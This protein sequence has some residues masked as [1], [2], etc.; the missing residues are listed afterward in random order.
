[1][2]DRYR[3][4]CIDTITD[5]NKSVATRRISGAGGY[6]DWLR[7]V[8]AALDIPRARVAGLSYGGWLAAQL[9]LRASE[10]V[11]HMVLLAPGGTLAPFSSQFLA[12]TL[13]QMLLRSPSRLRDSL[14]WL[15]STPDALADP[16]VDL[17]RVSMLTTRPLRRVI[18]PTVLTDDELRRIRMPVTVLIGEREVIYRG[19]PKAAL[20][21]AQRLIPNVRTR[22]LAGANHMLTLDCPDALITEMSGALA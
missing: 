4:Y 12:R 1:M 6:V 9:G 14:Q 19:G 21:R 8:F 20:A 15:S 3:C 10:C 17:L 13:T 11:S 22:L 5:A 7:Q 18:V 2:S 16:G